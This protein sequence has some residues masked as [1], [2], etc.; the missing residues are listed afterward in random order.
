MTNEILQNK[1]AEIVRLCNQKIQDQHKHEST[2][3]Y[4]YNDYDDGRI[5]GQGALARRILHI[6]NKFNQ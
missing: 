3:G 1:I 4:S 5:V 2:S 6:I